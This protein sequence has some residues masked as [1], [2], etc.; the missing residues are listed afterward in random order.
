MISA[1]LIKD[2]ESRGF[3]LEFPAY[4]RKEE[5]IA[6]IVKSDNARLSLALPL[7]M[8]EG[9]D[10]DVVK[11]LLSR[12]AVAQLNKAILLTNKIL[13]AEGEDNGLIR[14]MIKKNRIS[15]KTASAE[16]RQYHDA[17]K[18]ALQKGLKEEEMLLS[19]DIKLRTALDTNKALSTLF[20]E[21]KLRVMQKIFNH[22][23]L[24]DTEL[25][26]YYRAIRPLIHAILHTEM[27]KYV[28]IIDAVKK[29]HH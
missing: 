21:G 17:Y 19:Q 12:T 13:I 20:S 18:S 28:K 1:R 2:L 15:G 6:E 25:K 10:H 11:R 7:L 22:S 27:Q 16:F 23:K 4:P 26:Y 8:R 24:T 14:E 3:Y 29:E 9:F 5:E